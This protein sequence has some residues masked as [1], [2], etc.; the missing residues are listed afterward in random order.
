[1][2]ISIKDLHFTYPTGVEAVRG[3]SLEMRAGER[4][5]IIGQNGAGK[6]TLVKHLNGLLRPTRGEVHVGDWNT[7]EHPVAHLARRVGF[8]FQNPDEQIFKNRV[9]DEVAFG[10]RNLGLTRVEIETRVQ[11][12]LERTGIAELADAHPY[13]L[14]PT[15]RKWVALASV[16]AMDTPILVLD[17][18][19]TGQDARGVAHL[20]ALVDELARSG[21]T[22]I[23][24]SHDIDF[25]AEHFDRVVVMKQGAVIA[26]GEKHAVL[27]QSATLAETFVEPP[28]ITRLG[29]ALELPKTVTTVEEFLEAFRGRAFAERGD[30]GGVPP[31]SFSSLSVEET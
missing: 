27:G 4:V 13:D 3:V 22:V 15:L 26:D 8:L 5:A 30:W 29:L 9:A 21:K 7:R 1:M 18:P 14:L 24:I 6:T 25:C 16:L 12:A 19:T 31:H 2:N 23:A 11:T 28:Q 10:P 17:E 20:G